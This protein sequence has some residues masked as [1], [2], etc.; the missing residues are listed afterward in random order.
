MGLILDTNFIITAER[1]TRRP[2]TRRVEAFLTLWA[3]ENLFITHTIAG[4][5]ACGQ[6]ARLRRDWERLCRPFPILPL[7]TEV[8]WQYGEIYRHL[9]AE[10]QLI[11]ANDMWIAAAALAYG[12]ALVTNNEA[13]FRR[14]SG[15]VVHSY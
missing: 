6:S 8:T 9:A 15:L 10:G 5:L 12:Y 4:E 3:H 13:E 7:T 1:E 2:T 14:V 11:G